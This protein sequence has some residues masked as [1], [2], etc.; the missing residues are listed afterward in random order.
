MQSTQEAVETSKHFY[1]LFGEENISNSDE[2]TQRM[3]SIFVESVSGLREGILQ[4][5]CYIMIST[6][7]D[8]SLNVTFQQIEQIVIRLKMIKRLWSVNGSKII[9]PVN[10][11]KE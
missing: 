8:V 9:T 10:D 3:N 5:K 6:F 2:M 1:V 4:T 11:S 7:Q